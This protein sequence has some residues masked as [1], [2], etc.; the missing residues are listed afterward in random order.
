[1]RKPPGIAIQKDCTGRETTAI[2]RFALDNSIP[3]IF[4]ENPE[5]VPE[6]YMPVGSCEFFETVMGMET[7]PH[8]FP[9]FCKAYVQRKWQV[10]TEED[11]PLPENRDVFLKPADTLKRFTGYIRKPGDHQ[12]PGP[13]IVQ[14]IV[15][16]VTE[17]RYYIHK[18]TPL[19][20]EWYPTE[21]TPDA[22]PIPEAPEF[23]EDIFI[24]NDWSGTLDF[25]TTEDGK[26]LLVEAHPPYAC[27][28][29]G[30][31]E[32][33]RTYSHWLIGGWNYLK[34]LRDGK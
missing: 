19:A 9:D 8:H 32:H 13:W 6:G 30:D 15:N 28:W 21:K 18:G 17:F 11:G 27:G 16:F 2:Q 10:C 4:V 14:G 33:Y 7:R 29:Y 23:P 5:N 34:E 25:G 22:D 31:S 20:G 26:F 3:C 12:H 24:P 1:M